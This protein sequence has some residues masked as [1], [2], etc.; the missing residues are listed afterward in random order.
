MK[1]ADNGGCTH[2]G[3]RHAYTAAEI[4]LALV[5]AVGA[6]LMARTFWRLMTVGAGFDPHNVLT[7]TTDVSRPRYSGNLIGYYHE[8]LERLRAVPGIEGAAMTSLIPMDYTERD[9]LLFAEHPVPDNTSAPYA[10]PISV[11]TDYFRV[12]RIPLR[13]GRLFTGQDTATTP[14]VAVIN[15]TCARARFPHEN[16][17]GTHIQLGHS[18]WI[19]IVGY[20]NAYS[21][22]LVARCVVS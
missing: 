11:S 1:G 4:A 21:G 10:D 20:N 2:N 12:M 3:L 9:Q 5:L 8:V 17:I 6:G 22:Q 16:P 7:L 18:P 13:R 14:R 19:T 15:E